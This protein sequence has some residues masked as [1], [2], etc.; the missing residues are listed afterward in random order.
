MP[1]TR[2]GMTTEGQ[3]RV[4]SLAP[5]AHPCQYPSRDP[6]A[7]MI[8]LALDRDRSEGICGEPL[9]RRLDLALRTRHLDEI[10]HMVQVHDCVAFRL[11]GRLPAQDERIAHFEEP[12]V[13]KAGAR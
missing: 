1:G 8:L 3:W 13:A 4:V 12:E 10:V 6:C 7:V 11:C 2:P 9:K 5:G